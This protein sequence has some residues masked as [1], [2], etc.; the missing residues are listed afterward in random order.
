[1]TE[2]LVKDKKNKNTKANILIDF[3]KLFSKA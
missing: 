2:R 1:M 3:F